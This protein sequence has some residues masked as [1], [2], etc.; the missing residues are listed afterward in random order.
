M[1]KNPEFDQNDSKQTLKTILFKKKHFLQHNY[2]Y[3]MKSIK[4]GLLSV[5]AGVGGGDP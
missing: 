3:F 1:A 5:T 4:P 2:G